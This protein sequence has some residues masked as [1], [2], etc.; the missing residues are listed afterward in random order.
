MIRIKFE[1]TLAAY[2]IIYEMSYDL[3]WISN[4]IANWASRIARKIRS[5]VRQLVGWE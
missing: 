5:R 2:L 1:L 4:A 3:Y